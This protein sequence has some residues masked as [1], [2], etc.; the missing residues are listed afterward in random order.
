MIVPLD[1]SSQSLR[2]LDFALPLARRFG[3]SVQLIHVYVGAHQ[4]ST[5]ATA[6]VLWSEAEAK[7]HLAD[8][9]EFVF[10]TRPR[11][12]DCHLRIG[13]P[14]REIIAAAEELKADLIVMATHGHSGFKHLTLG[15]TTEKVIRRARC[16]VLVVREATRGPIKTTEEGIV[17]LKI[18]VPV[19]FS[20]CAREGAR[21]ASVFAAKVGADLLLMHV[22][23]PPDYMAAEGTAADPNWP[24]L[25]QKAMLD[26]NDRMD[27]MVNFLSLVNISADTEVV[28]GS[29]VEKLAEETRHSDIDMVITSTH[30][31]TGL[32]QVL[33]GSVA[34]QLVRSA[35][36]PVLVV[37][38]HRRK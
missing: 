1:F 8:E 37:P 24:T 12:E 27:E 36:C 35:S 25:L 33:V 34:E 15:S 18:L 4:F 2:A 19:D 17:L 16:P 6:P 30:G 20:D 38:S 26:A 11:G 9:V 14:D 31:Y 21:Y 3:A 28:V 10:G 23:Q 13:N 29:P 5:V 32:R 22:V 7:R